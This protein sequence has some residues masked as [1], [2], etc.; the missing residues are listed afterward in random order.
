M[1]I[2]LLSLAIYVLGVAVF[3]EILIYA[4]KFKGSN[5][6]EVVKTFFKNLSTKHILLLVVSYLIILSIVWVLF[7]DW[8]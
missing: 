1:K 7:V 6:T 3:S 8:K 4:K 2:I 5:D